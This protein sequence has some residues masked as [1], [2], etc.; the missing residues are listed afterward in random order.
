MARETRRRTTNQSC[1]LLHEPNE[2]PRRTANQCE[3]DRELSD[4]TPTPRPSTHNTLVVQSVSHHRKTAVSHHRKNEIK[5]LFLASTPSSKRAH[6]HGLGPNRFIR[7]L[8]FGYSLFWTS[9]LYRRRFLGRRVYRTSCRTR[10]GDNVRDII[11]A[12]H[13]SLSAGPLIFCAL[14][15]CAVGM[16]TEG[17]KKRCTLG[18]CGLLYERAA[19]FIVGLYV[20][21][22]DILDL[23]S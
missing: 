4:G 18:L 14:I 2:H 20:C 1:Q 19:G 3:Y 8:S 7:R 22:D 16:T 23:I 21:I 11:R 15:F 17:E 6:L 10:E 12:G 5:R 9:L 13:V